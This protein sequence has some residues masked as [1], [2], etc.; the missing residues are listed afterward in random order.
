MKNDISNRSQQRHIRPD[1]FRQRRPSVGSAPLTE[2]AGLT[3]PATQ[4][5]C[6]QRL[7][8]GL[9]QHSQGHRPWKSGKESRIWPTAIVNTM[10]S[11]ATQEHSSSSREAVFERTRLLLRLHPAAASPEKTPP[12]LMTILALI[13]R[14]NTAL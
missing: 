13:L 14:V 12:A 1:K 11:V 4:P 6:Q 7:A 8:K 10:S 2:D 5:P 9:F 3:K